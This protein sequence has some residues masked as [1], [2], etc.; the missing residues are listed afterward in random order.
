MKWKQ[1]RAHRS[2]FNVPL[3]PPHDR[4]ARAATGRT[5][6]GEF[7]NQTLRAGQA[8]AETFGGR[9]TVAHGGVEIGDARP[10]VFE[11]ETQARAS[12]RVGGRLRDELPARGVLDG[13]ARQLRRDGGEARLV[14][15]AKAERS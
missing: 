10:F 9:E 13:V 3:E 5:L 14:E 2:A 11:D 7:V 6:N 1:F 12:V 4:D 15:E 8:F